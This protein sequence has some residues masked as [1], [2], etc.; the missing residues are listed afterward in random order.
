MINI[1]SISKEYVMGDNKLLALNNVDVSIN[2]GEFVSIMGSSGSGKSTLMNIIGCLDVPSH[3]DY[4]FRDNNI[5]NYSSNKLAEL[6]NKDIGFIFQNFNLLPRLNALENVILPL[7]Y[8][9]KSKKERVELALKALENVGL[10]DRTHHRP[11]QLSG[12]QQQRVSIARAIAGTPKLILADEPT[13]ALDSTTSLEIMKILNDLNKSGI[14]IVLVTHE[15]DI[16]KYGSRI[17]KM[18][19]GKILEDKKNVPN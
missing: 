13:G 8:S 4:F 15:D 1:T 17:I 16:A 19:D 18:K 11:N 3:G 7:L 9:G 6:R 10:K 14:T 2:E 5:S 12:G